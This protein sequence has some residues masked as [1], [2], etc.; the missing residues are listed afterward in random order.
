MKNK[1]I[2]IKDTQFDKSSITSFKSIKKEFNNKDCYVGLDRLFAK[3]YPK[4]EYYF[5]LWSNGERFSWRTENAEENAQLE[6]LITS[7]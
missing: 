7:E 4:V 5:V 3:S 2:Q 1:F 6:N